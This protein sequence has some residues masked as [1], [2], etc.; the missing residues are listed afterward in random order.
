MTYKPK[1]GEITA[2]QAK[3]KISLCYLIVHKMGGGGGDHFLGWP[4][5]TNGYVTP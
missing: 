3:I 1:E 5:V 2:L 4:L